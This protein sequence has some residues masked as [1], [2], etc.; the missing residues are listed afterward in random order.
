VG[1]GTTEPYRV[2]GTPDVNHAIAA[3]CCLICCHCRRRRRLSLRR[4]DPDDEDDPDDDD[5]DPDDDPDDEEP[6]EI[7]DRPQSGSPFP[8]VAQ[9]TM[10][11]STTPPTVP[12]MIPVWVDVSC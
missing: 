10:K 5:D 6:P 2:C 11:S 8:R 7:D 3:L 4:R 1:G 12:M 9:R